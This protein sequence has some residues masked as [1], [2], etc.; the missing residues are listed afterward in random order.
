MIVDVIDLDAC[1]D[2][3]QVLVRLIED[4]PYYIYVLQ[5]IWVVIFDCPINVD[6]A[7]IELE[8][9]LGKDE[10]GPTPINPVKNWKRI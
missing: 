8:A 4:K 7:N 3:G 10:E 1:H 2:A 9:Y 6:D 5:Q